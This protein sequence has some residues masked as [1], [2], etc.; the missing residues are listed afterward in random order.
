ML[1]MRVIGRPLRES[2]RCGLNACVSREMR[3]ERSV[4]SNILILDYSLNSTSG[5]QFPLPVSIF[6][7]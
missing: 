7:N 2:V 1:P 6:A 5:C 3:V 4:S